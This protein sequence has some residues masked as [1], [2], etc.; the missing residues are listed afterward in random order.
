LVYLKK[1]KGRTKLNFTYKHVR[2]EILSALENVENATIYYPDYDVEPVSIVGQ[3]QGLKLSIQSSSYHKVIQQVLGREYL[4]W[5][6]VLDIKAGRR[7]RSLTVTHVVRPYPDDVIDEFCLR[8]EKD[9]VKDEPLYFS[10]HGRGK[11]TIRDYDVQDLDEED[12]PK[13]V[14]GEYYD[15]LVTTEDVRCMLY[16]VFMMYLWGVAEDIK[17]RETAFEKTQNRYIA[18]ADV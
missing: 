14:N 13:V 10:V 2:A 4:P 3:L 9:G 11:V 12:N 1:L 6:V 7:V 15:E 8:G 5:E 17:E 16:N 18:P